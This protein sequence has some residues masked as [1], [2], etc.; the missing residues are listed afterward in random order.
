MKP[1]GGMNP[2]LSGGPGEQSS[3]MSGEDKALQ[4]VVWGIQKTP[5]WLSSS[6]P[7]GDFSHISSRGIRTGR[8]GNYSNESPGK[9]FEWQQPKL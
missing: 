3:M 4:E 5:S 6:S 9:C 8:R 1:D 7:A 2:T